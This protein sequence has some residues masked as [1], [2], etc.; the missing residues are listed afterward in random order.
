MPG[1]TCSVTPHTH[2]GGLSPRP[3][4]VVCSSSVTKS[5]ASKRAGLSCFSTC[6]VLFVE[7][8]TGWGAGRFRGVLSQSLRVLSGGSTRPVRGCLHGAR[9]S[10]LPRDRHLLHKLSSRVLD[11]DGHT[12]ETRR[13]LRLGTKGTRHTDGGGRTLAPPGALPGREPNDGPSS[14]KNRLG[15]SQVAAGVVARSSCQVDRCV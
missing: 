8:I 9:V 11:R 5:A 10:P 1:E 4:S 6:V 2:V 12:A 13:T 3:A 14:G 15:S 7:T